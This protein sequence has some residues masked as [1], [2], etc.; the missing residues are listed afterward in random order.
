MNVKKIITILSLSFAGVILSGISYKNTKLPQK[1]TAYYEKD[2]TVKVANTTGSAITDP[3]TEP[4]TGGVIVIPT[5]PPDHIVIPTIKPSQTPEAEKN[6]FV[7][8]SKGKY[9]YKDGVALKEKWLTINEKTYYFRKNGT[10]AT[11]VYR[12]NGVLY[13]FNKD[14]SLAKNRWLTIDGRKYYAG[15]NGQAAIG[16]KTIEDKGYYFESSGAM[17]TGFI[18]INGKKYYFG[19]N[20][21]K[22]SGKKKISRYMCYFKKTGALYRKIDTKKKMVALTYDDGPSNHTNTILKVLKKHDSVATFF[23]VGNRIASY[24]S[25][26]KKIDKMGCEIGNHTYEHKILSGCNRTQIRKQIDQTNNALKKVIGKKTIITRPPGGSHNKTIDGIINTPVILWSVDTLDW[27]NRNASSVK[28]AVLKNVKDGDIVL[29]HDLYESTA[30]ASKK[31]IPALVKRGYQLVT[32]S[33][34]SD[35]R[36]AM[37][38]GGTYSSFPAK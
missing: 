8:T 3:T 9:Y 1:V 19:K 37:K 12:I 7:T 38:N 26:V 33:E 36:K 18:D 21:V 5:I 2:A 6:G 20:G 13:L 17:H 4:A 15:E 16:Y 10:A 29:M 11:G 25:V 23:E 31:I 27:K 35:C 34:L 28:S 24:R 14:A 32:V 22:V 30:D